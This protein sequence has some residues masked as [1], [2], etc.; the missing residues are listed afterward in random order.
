MTFLFIEG[1]TGCISNTL[2]RFLGAVDRPNNQ[3]LKEMGQLDIYLLITV[4]GNSEGN[5]RT[6]F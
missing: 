3:V 6:F 5:S 2:T 1:H 4:P